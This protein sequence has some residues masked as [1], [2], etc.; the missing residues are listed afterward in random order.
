M[1][2]FMEEAHREHGIVQN[3]VSGYESI[4]FSP[5]APSTPTIQAHIGFKLLVKHYIAKDPAFK[6]WTDHTHTLKR[7]LIFEAA[8]DKPN[9]ISK[10]A[11]RRM[12]QRGTCHEWIAILS[13]CPALLSPHCGGIVYKETFTHW[14]NL[15][16]V[17]S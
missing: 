1:E 17:F 7:G 9:G 5:N 6:P 12:L 16:F 14:R 13:P 10:F 11:R 4:A 8:T 15:L 2:K 3:P